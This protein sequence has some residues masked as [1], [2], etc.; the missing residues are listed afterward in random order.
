MCGIAGIVSLAGRPVDPAALK[1]M[2]DIQ[3][4]R[5][6]DDA[7]YLLARPGEPRTGEGGYWLGFSDAR[8]AHLNEHLPVFGGSYFRE[9]TG[10]N[11][12]SVALGHRRLAI[13]DPTPAGHQPMPSSDQRYWIVFNG[14]IYN[15]PDLRRGLAG[16][17]H[18]FQTRSDT[19]VLLHLW[20][21]RGADCLPLLDG[22]FALA[23]YD[24]VEN[25]LVLAR[26]RFG[27]KQLYFLAAGEFLA[28]ASEAKGVL[29]SGLVRPEINPP[30]LAEY[31]TFQNVFGRETLFKGIE[32][33]QPGEMLEV[34]PG[35]G[36]VPAL[37]RWFGGFPRAE[38]GR[39]RTDLHEEVAAAF[40]AAVT[41]QLVS[42]VPVGS[43]L[44]GGMD[45]GSI[46]AVAGRTLGRL[47]TFT[48]GFDMTNVSGIEQGFDERGMAERLSYLLQTEHY[49]VVLH[50]GDMPAAME[51][52]TW[53]MDDPRVGMCHQN[54]YVAKLASRFVKVCLA[55]TGGDELFGGYP[56]RYLREGIPTGPED[57]D[58]SYFAYWHRLLDPGQLPRLLAPEMRGH[59]A[60]P[61]QTF[62]EVCAG[63]PAWREDLSPQENLLDR[64]LRF[65][66]A[67]FLQG[68]FVTEDRV[69]MAHS[70]ETR[71]PFLDNTL[72][73]LAFSIPP[74]AK[75]ALAEPGRLLSGGHLESTA[76][77]AV[78]R[79]AMEHV[80]PPEFTR[81][82]KQ[83]FSPPDENWFR[84]PS[85][86]YIKSVLLDE[87]TL[88][89]PWFD[90]D[91]VRARLGEHFRGE[92]N[93]R[94][95]IWSLL[96]LEWL[97]RHFVDA[98]AGG[99]VA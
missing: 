64:A 21:E 75:V 76:G 43:Y 52:I 29:A 99:A 38:S 59:L 32:L 66:F 77:K 62:A 54:W 42:D 26:D 51:R 67:T 45:S 10:R 69:S 8:F 81:Q 7:G 88:G 23:V 24:R 36:V 86:E 61:R 25:R 12:F 20:E 6:P 22:M 27:V 87:R 33:L 34:E 11:A 70:L 4:H 5:G 65:E 91:F 74:S 13:I 31:V 63:L 92:Q 60:R 30:A 2:C 58:R 80:L 3:A 35:R 95:L 49:A 17:G 16:R 50:A 41:R 97:Q 44:S 56:W 9:Q 78:L 48:G 89:R 82:P 55:G 40:S 84:G 14:E 15:F 73:D 83:G 19:E 90:Q 85:M 46:V 98:P 28:F 79:R 93:H 18:V 94:L 71:V 47:L 57:F 96:S 72:A 39:P 37:R 53:H 68:L 1:S